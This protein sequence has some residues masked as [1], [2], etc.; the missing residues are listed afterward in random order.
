MS[1]TEAIE[2]ARQF[3][4]RWIARPRPV[5]DPAVRVIGIPHVGGGAAV[6]NPWATVLPDRVEL[7]AVRLP[8]RENR[9]TEEPVGDLDELLDGLAPAL[10]PHLDRPYVLFGHSS[11]SL[12]AF[13]LARRLRSMSAPMAAALVVSSSDAPRLRRTEDLH[14]LPGPE[15]MDRVE[16]FGGMARQVLGDPDLLAIL[17]RIVRADYR[18]TETLRYRPEAPLDIPVTA[19]AGRHDTFVDL[20]AVLAWREETTG[21]FD[22]QILDAGHFIL[23]EAATV[24]SHVAGTVTSER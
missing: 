20:D 21:P 1:I 17:E 23:P 22:L 11:G 24:V 8:G 5:I 2:G 15:L 19:I 13:E 4:G 7:C 6:F 14:R 10:L 3:A 18:I 12:I 16:R 9:I